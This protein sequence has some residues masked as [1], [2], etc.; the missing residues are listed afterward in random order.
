MGLQVFVRFEGFTGPGD[1]GCHIARADGR[2]TWLCLRVGGLWWPASH[3][4]HQLLCGMG[5]QEAMIYQDISM[6]QGRGD[7]SDVEQGTDCRLGHSNPTRCGTK[8]SRN[9]LVRKRSQISFERSAKSSYQLTI[10]QSNVFTQVAHYWQH[11]MVRNVQ[12]WLQVRTHGRIRVTVRQSRLSS[13]SN[14]QLLHMKRPEDST[15]TV[16][17]RAAHAI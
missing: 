8:S 16:R 5:L 11:K 3:A 17:G 9:F 13:A 14:D 15:A 6:L 7:P 10:D 2:P 1:V 4:A 12:C